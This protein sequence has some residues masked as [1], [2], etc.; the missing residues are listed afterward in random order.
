MGKQLLV[1]LKLF[2]F[3]ELKILETLSMF[4]PTKQMMFFKLFKAINKHHFDN[5]EESSVID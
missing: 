4:M 3:A 5:S 1:D 2:Y